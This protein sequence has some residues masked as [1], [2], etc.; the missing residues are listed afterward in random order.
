M[1]IFEQIAEQKIQEALARG[2]FDNL[3]GAGKPIELDDPRFMRREDRVALHIL[4]R[5]G[6]LPPVLAVRKELEVRLENA[7]RQMDIRLQR[8]ELFRKQMRGLL[9]SDRNA[10]RQ[11]LEQFGFAVTHP[12]VQ[13][14]YELES[15]RGK[16]GS[17]HHFWRKHR[18]Y[19]ALHQQAAQA[20]V[21][22]LA[23]LKSEEERAESAKIQYELSHQCSLNLPEIT[24]TA[25]EKRIRNR[26]FE[27]LAPLVENDDHA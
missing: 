1:F 16:E 18:Q 22:V 27:E 14:F 9:P 15:G 3:P 2:E 6:Y 13:R 10:A 19:R 26:L 21:H 5:S 23:E 24:S 7:E 25:F 8:L 17:K 20:F 11:R 4:K 12:A